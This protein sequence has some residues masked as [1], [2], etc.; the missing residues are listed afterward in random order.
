VIDKTPKA[1]NM[2]FKA[3]YVPKHFATWCGCYQNYFGLLKP[4]GI[5]DYVP[6]LDK[7]GNC[8][9]VANKVA[10]CNPVVDQHVPDQVLKDVSVFTRKILWT[11]SVFL[12]IYLIILLN[13]RI[14]VWNFRILLSSPCRLLVQCLDI[15]C[16]S[17]LMFLKL[18]MWE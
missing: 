18:V 13:K 11:K 14:I 5:A 17:I 16:Q 10:D 4:A 12:V 8:D 7:T 9:P 2:K 15:Q 6:T 1:N 3:H